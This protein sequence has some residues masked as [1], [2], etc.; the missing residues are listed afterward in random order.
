[1]GGGNECMIAK[2]PNELTIAKWRDRGLAWL[3]DFAIVSAG[4]GIIYGIW[5][6]TLMTMHP[7]FHVTTSIVF[8][9][10]WIILESRD[11]Q[12][13]GKMLLHLKTTKIDGTQADIKDLVIGSFGKSF[14]LP[15]DVILGWIFSNKKKQ[16]LFNRFSNTIVIK[17]DEPEEE[18]VSY[19]MD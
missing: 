5:N 4:I 18:F 2:H 13:I 17:I 14:L 19:K 7:S 3:V 8:F 11:G 1:M 12:S 15:L 10:Y 16:R 6:S 9:A